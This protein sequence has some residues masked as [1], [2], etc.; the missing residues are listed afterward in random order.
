ME[1]WIMPL[2]L[3]VAAAVSAWRDPRK[4]R[5]GLALAAAVLLSALYLLVIVLT[6]ASET[7]D[8]GVWVVLGL[9]LLL[10]ALVIVLGVVLVLNGLTMVRKEGR[11]LAN[12]LSLLLGIAILGYVGLGIASVMLSLSQVFLFLLLLGLPVGYLSFG[13]V[14]YLGYS[15]LYQACT[16][17]WGRPV[18]AIVVLGSGLVGGRVPPLLASRLD[19]GRAVLE[20]AR[21]AG[22]DPLMITSGGKGDDETRAEAHAMSEY[23]VEHGVDPDRIAE[24]D[25]SRT[26]EENLA[27]TAR[28]LAARLIT[29]RVAVVTNSFH[30]FRAA[31]LMRR[32][33]IPGYSLGSATAG[34]YW[35]S[36]TIREYVAILRDSR[37]F[38][39]VGLG[40][41]LLP[42]AGLLIVGLLDAV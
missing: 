17:R 13:F 14:A 30:A 25:R 39:A 26:T 36:A 6:V 21:L 15:Q 23:L 10:L 5:I 28:V 31:L 33:G 24:E 9:F 38:N 37:W 4:L 29:G 32:V 7:P 12:L 40:L 20:R 41:S 35:P 42:L 3:V 27:N 19:R 2:V 18:E 16:K 11:H 8:L 22:R 34:Y 1:P